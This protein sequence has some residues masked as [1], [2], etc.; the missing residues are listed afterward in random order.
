MWGL[1][2]AASQIASTSRGTDGGVRRKPHGGTSSEN[3]ST[4]RRFSGRRVTTSP[5][6]SGHRMHCI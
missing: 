1:L 6:A 2:T 5:A 4:Y 3:D